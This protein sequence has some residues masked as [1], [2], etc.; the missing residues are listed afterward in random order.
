M[1]GELKVLKWW[2]CKAFIIWFAG[3]ESERGV[4]N[5]MND[6]ISIWQNRG[7][8]RGR[9]SEAWEMNRTRSLKLFAS[10]PIAVFVVGSDFRLEDLIIF[11]EVLSSKRKCLVW[12]E[13]E[14]NEGEKGVHPPKAWLTQT[15]FWRAWMGAH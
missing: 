4:H 12:N 1:G 13:K 6:N 8:Q 3:K 7:E 11:L 15:V 9:M 5:E 14:G 2:T 10:G